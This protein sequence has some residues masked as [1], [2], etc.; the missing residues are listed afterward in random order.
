MSLSASKG[1]KDT[2]DQVVRIKDIAKKAGVS[3]GTVDRV[4]HKRSGVSAKSYNKVMKI[5]E[6]MNYE[7]NLMARALVSKK[8]HKIAALI[9]DAR[10]DSYWEEPREGIAKAANNMKQYGIRVAEYIFDPTDKN[11]FIERAELVTKQVPDG[12]LVAPI[13]YSE[14]LPFLQKWKE[15]N[16]PIV[17]FNTQISEFEPLSYIGQD[18]YQSGLLAGKLIHYGQH[19]PCTVAI[20]HIDE[21]ISNAAHLQKKEKGFRN[22]FKQNDPNGQFKIITVQMNRSNLSAFAKAMDD[23]VEDHTDLSSIFV[24]TCK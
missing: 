6:E 12:I 24:T 19:R 22:Y 17:L 7:P 14:S 20:L 18:S 3:V 23:L 5:L 21:D 10:M 13:F 9:P 1:M 16:I 2:N 4:I 15:M 8:I 11:S